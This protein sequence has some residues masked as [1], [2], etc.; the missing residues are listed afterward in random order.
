MHDS[1][2][3]AALRNVTRAKFRQAV[4]AL[5]ETRAALGEKRPIAIRG[6][7]AQPGRQ[8]SAAAAAVA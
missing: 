6:M 5:V 3:L 2:L 7:A 4:S 1:A 8:G